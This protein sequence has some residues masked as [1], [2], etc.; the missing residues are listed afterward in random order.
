MA[1]HEN[2][3]VPPGFIVL[4]DLS[5][6]DDEVLR[7]YAHVCVGG[8]WKPYMN[9]I[10]GR[11]PVIVPDPGIHTDLENYSPVIPASYQCMYQV[12]VD[13]ANE[14]ITG[15]NTFAWID[16]SRLTP[17]ALSIIHTFPMR[18]P[19]DIDAATDTFALR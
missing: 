5:L 9:G 6:L 12:Y 10:G 2:I 1:T 11:E 7:G 3:P 18:I 16:K 13:C 15:N 19:H 4:S 17:Y 8:S 14:I